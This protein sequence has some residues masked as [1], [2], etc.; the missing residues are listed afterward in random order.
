MTKRW[1]VVT[2]AA[3][4]AAQGAMASAAPTVEE[5]RPIP[6]REQR[7]NCYDQI[8]VATPVNPAQAAAERQAE[9]ER[10]FG[11]AESA[12]PQAER[13]EAEAVTAKIVGIRDGRSGKI[14]EL[15]NGQEWQIASNGNLQRWLRA[16]QVAT[17]KRGMLS[18][19]RLTVDGVTGTETVRRLP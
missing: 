5:C 15:E 19:Y 17:I 10:N 2:G 8:P 1:I 18:G 11:L 13:A 9:Q 16:D 7:L 6:D 3:V 14:V 12:K 4:L